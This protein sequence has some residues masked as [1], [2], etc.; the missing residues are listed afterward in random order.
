MFGRRRKRNVALPHVNRPDAMPVMPDMPVEEMFVGG[1]P[2]PFTLDE[3]ARIK[4]NEAA[5]ALLDDDT[6][7]YVVVRLKKDGT[8]DGSLRV[9]GHVLPP[10]RNHFRATLERIARHGLSS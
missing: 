9:C 8:V 10:W 4:R 3:Q 1:D 6:M 5:A 7:G 2:S